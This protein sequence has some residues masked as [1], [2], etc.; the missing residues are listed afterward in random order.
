MKDI[1]ITYTSDNELTGKK[2]LSKVQI[3][4]VPFMGKVDM[5]KLNKG[6]LSLEDIDR[7]L[8]KPPRRKWT[9]NLTLLVDGIAPMPSPYDNN[10]DDVNMSLYD[11]IYTLRYRRLIQQAIRT[12]TTITLELT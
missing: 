3:N 10:K 8:P 5:P 12:G 1:Y 9:K 6:T 4:Q 2:T 11:V 7:P